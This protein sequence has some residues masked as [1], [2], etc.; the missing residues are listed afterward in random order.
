MN[1][2]RTTQVPNVVF[3][4]LLPFLTYAE[5]KIL[6]VVIRQTYGWIN[7]RTGK[8]KVYDRITYSQFIKKT[9]LSRRS[10]NTAMTSLYKKGLITRASHVDG[11][12]SLLRE[13]KGQRNIFYRFVGIEGLTP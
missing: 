4:S 2:Q 8:R 3:D 12:L 7:K 1:Y 11:T 10:V 9:G 6:L 13:V 5:L